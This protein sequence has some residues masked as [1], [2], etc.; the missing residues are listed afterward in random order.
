MTSEIYNLIGLGSKNFG[1]N[2]A[3]FL[4][5]STAA[6]GLKKYLLCDHQKKSFKVRFSISHLCSI[7]LYKKVGNGCICLCVD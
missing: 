5:F 3:P 7:F 6:G 4:L 2:M 1:I